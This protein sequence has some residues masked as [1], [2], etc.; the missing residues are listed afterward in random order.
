[1]LARDKR[2][3]QT[4]EPKGVDWSDGYPFVP[5][6]FGFLALFLDY[7]RE[8]VHCCCVSAAAK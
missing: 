4:N 3:T 6:D 1:M 2:A 5:H 7:P 8:E